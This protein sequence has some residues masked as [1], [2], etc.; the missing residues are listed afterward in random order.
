MVVLTGAANFDSNAYYLCWL[1]LTESN[2]ARRWLW[3]SIF[4]FLV[5][6]VDASQAET[7]EL[8]QRKDMDLLR[9]SAKH[10]EMWTPAAVGADWS[11]FGPPQCAICSRMLQSIDYE[12][13]ALYPLLERLI[14]ER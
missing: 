12:Q 7:L 8:L 13:L 6:R 1:Q 3:R 9:R 4:E 14:K 11:A 2:F 5:P 10:N